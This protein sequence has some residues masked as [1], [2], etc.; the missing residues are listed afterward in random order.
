MIGNLNKAR[1]GNTV[2]VHWA[3]PRSEHSAN[4]TPKAQQ[5]NEARNKLTVGAQG[6]KESLELSMCVHESTIYKSWCMAA[7]PCPNRT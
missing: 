6:L 3:L 5:I 4:T 7:A 1:I 2:N